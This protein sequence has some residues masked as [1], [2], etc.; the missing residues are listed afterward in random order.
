MIQIGQEDICIGCLFDGHGCDHAPGAHGAQDGHDFPVA[1]RRRFMD[2]PASKTSRI[3]PRHRSGHTAFIQEDQLVQR[4]R[5]D[6]LKELRPPLLIGF[7]V[8]LGCVQR[9]FFKRT[10]K[11]FS[12]R[13]KCWV[14]MPTPTD[15]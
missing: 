13:H 9:L 15:R 7:G 12:T 1:A 11:R 6:F 3:E 14:L 8:S 10:P 5:M 2:A 4:G